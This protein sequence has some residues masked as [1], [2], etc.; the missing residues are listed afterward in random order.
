MTWADLT[1]PLTFSLHRQAGM[2]ELPTSMATMY[3]GCFALPVL[4][5]RQSGMMSQLHAKTNTAGDWCQSLISKAPSFILRFRL[6]SSLHVCIEWKRY[7]HVV[8]PVTLQYACSSPLTV[9]AEILCE[10]ACSMAYIIITNLHATFNVMSC[11]VLQHPT[12]QH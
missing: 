3:I 12:E 6:T 2:T 8:D 9:T 5:G 4:S 1:R 11:S 10:T 7:I